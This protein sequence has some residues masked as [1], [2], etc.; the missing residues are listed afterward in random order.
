MVGKAR[1]KRARSPSSMRGQL[2]APCACGAGPSL[3]RFADPSCD[4][5]PDT[6]PQRLR[7]PERPTA[8]EER[9]KRLWQFYR[10]MMALRRAREKLDDEKPERD[11]ERDEETLPGLA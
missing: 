4:G 1:G 2:V 6:P 8:R 10:W 5:P 11:F 9:Y 3:R 7:G